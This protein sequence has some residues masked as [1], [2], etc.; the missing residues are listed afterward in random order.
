[1]HSG[2][3]EVARRHLAF[4]HGTEVIRLFRIEGAEVHTC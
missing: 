4:Q 3:P 2:A 1:M